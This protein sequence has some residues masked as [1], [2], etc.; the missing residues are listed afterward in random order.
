MGEIVDWRVFSTVL[1]GKCTAD[2]LPVSH[3]L[4]IIHE[5]TRSRPRMWLWGLSD[6]YHPR[7]IGD[8]VIPQKHLILHGDG[9]GD[10]HLKSLP[11][12][13]GTEWTD[14]KAWWLKKRISARN[15]MSKQKKSDTGVI[16]GVKFI[17][18]QKNSLQWGATVYRSIQLKK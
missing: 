3:I 13:L 14:L 1:L 12:Y 10:V 9:H 4:Y 15:T 6:T 2:Q 11:A 16:S 17:L 5:S 7:V 8:R 18:F